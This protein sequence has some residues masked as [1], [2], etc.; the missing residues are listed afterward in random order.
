LLLV[1][2]ATEKQAEFVATAADLHHR[3]FGGHL[4]RYEII[5]AFIFIKIAEGIRSLRHWAGDLSADR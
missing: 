2:G 5:Q 3:L 1:C 4:Q